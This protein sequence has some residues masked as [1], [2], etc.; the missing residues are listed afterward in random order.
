MRTR[1]AVAGGLTLL[2]FVLLAP[3]F[4]VVLD[5]S[6]DKLPGSWPVYAACGGLVS[7]LG[8]VSVAPPTKDRDQ[9]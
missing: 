5:G 3:L 1:E 2:G 7:L 6:G 4:A 8:G 9:P